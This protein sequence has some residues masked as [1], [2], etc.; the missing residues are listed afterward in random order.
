MRRGSSSCGQCATMRST[1]KLSWRGRVP[2]PGCSTRRVSCRG[3]RT[4]TIWPSWPGAVCRPF[5]RRGSNPTTSIRSIRCTRAFRP[6]AISSSNP[7]CRREGG[8]PDATLPRTRH[9]AGRPSATRCT[10]SRAAVPSWCS[11]TLRKSIAQVKYPSSTSMGCPHTG[12]RKRLCSTRAFGR[13]TSFTKRWCARPTPTKTNGVG[14]RR[15]ARPST[16]SPSTHTGATSSPCSTESTSYAAD[17]Q[18][19]TSSTSWRSR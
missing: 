1:A 6:S 10:S 11:D 17:R 9:R 4:S 19:S 3:I 12:W 14:A 5:R 16:P 8:G 15:S 18:T 13:K 2:F 7:P